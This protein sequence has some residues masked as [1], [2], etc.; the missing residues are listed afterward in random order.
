[1]STYRHPITGVELNDIDVKNAALGPQEAV[2]VHILSQE[3][4]DRTTI[5][6]ML[7]TNPARIIEVVKGSEHP[8][9]ANEALKL[10]TA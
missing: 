6:H 2:T 5:A 9:S 10:M 8:N 1:M 4:K 7:G 3:G